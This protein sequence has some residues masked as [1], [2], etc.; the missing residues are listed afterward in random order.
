MLENIEIEV[1]FLEIDKKSLLKKLYELGAKDKGEQL[2]DQTIIYDSHFKWRDENRS[3]RLRKYGNVTKLTY[4]ERV[5]KT[6]DGAREIEFEIGDYEKARAL[7]EKMGFVPFRREQKKRHTFEYKDVTI[8]IDTWP[9]VPT[10]VELEGA[11]ENDLKIVAKELGFN[12]EH[13]FF[14]HAGA[15]L[16]KYGIPVAQLTY[17]TFDRYE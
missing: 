1:R 15:I 16:E 14:D 2:L 11:S 4:K 10:Y 12:W 5:S 3:I 17:F 7:F 9:R 8:D 13:A 6:I